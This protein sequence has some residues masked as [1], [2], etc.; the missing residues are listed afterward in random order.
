[1][2]KLVYLID[3]SF[4][5]Q[6]R[7]FRYMFNKSIKVLK[8]LLDLFPYNSIDVDLSIKKTTKIKT[9][10]VLI[11]DSLNSYYV[12]KIKNEDGYEEKFFK[13]LAVI[14]SK[15]GIFVCKLYNRIKDSGNNN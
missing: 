1:M 15:I 8:R 9:P 2:K 4:I 14:K 5:K 7:C 13:K 12:S 10:K 11:I 3:I 6:D